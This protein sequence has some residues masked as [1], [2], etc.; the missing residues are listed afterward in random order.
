MNA[1][2]RRQFATGLIGL[3]P[4][5]GPPVPG[6]FVFESPGQGLA[7]G[8]RLRD[9]G[10]F[11]TPRERR[12]ASAV[13]VG[14]G[15][16]GLSAAWR[17]HQRGFH[18]FL[19]L[20]MEKQAGGNARSGANEVSAFPWAAHYLPVPDLRQTL[21]RELCA[22]LGLWDGHRWQERHLCHAPQERLFI[23][24]RWQEGI[25]PTIGLTPSDARQ[26]QRFFARVAELR[27]TGAFRIP[28]E[29][30]L[31]RATPSIRALDQM[32]FDEW[33]RAGGFY[34]P[35]L[36]WFLD[37]STR[38][39]YAT[40]LDAISAWAGL[41]YFAARAP[42][43]KGPLTWPEGNGWIVK[44]LLERVGGHVRTSSMVHHIRRQGARWLVFTEDALYETPSVV[45]AAPTWLASWIID[46]PPPP[47]PF[48]SVPWITANLTLH[49][50]PEN[51][52][53][54]YAW[55][56]VIFRS[57]SLG[58]VIATHQNLN[59]YQPRT[60]WTWYMALAAGRA[61]DQRRLLL[62]GDY[63][64][65]QERV[66]SDLELAHPDIRLCAA[67][68]DIFRIGH[69][70]PRPAPGAIFHPGRLHRARPSGSLVYANCDL[71]ALSLFEEALYHG[72][73]A[74][75]HLLHLHS[76]SGA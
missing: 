8:H 53:A 36:R 63:P 72:T 71:S 56:N 25:E 43:D 58:Y 1:P 49:R 29:E 74:A 30:G 31:A 57:P 51:R 64:Y 18:D 24:G 70:M 55:D 68:I 69:A 42:E 28:M 48:D 37:Y 12:R 65:W 19:V 10:R 3:A 17:F 67:R 62:G 44:R 13:I 23:H 22:D 40:H 45:F 4:K 39:D 32:T 33:L 9:R 60:V 2:S 14:G 38:D 61:A 6:G 20:E 66:L 26:F 11:H 76:R 54:E 7:Q 15:I 52:G 73:A 41:H 75:D 46:P 35:Y 5:S 16:A 47:W 59:L 27:Q 34:S 50:W 21:T